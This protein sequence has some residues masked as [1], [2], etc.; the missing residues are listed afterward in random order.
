MGVLITSTFPRDSPRKGKRMARC[1]MFQH[2]KLHDTGGDF[3]VADSRSHRSALW[4]I[5]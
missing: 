1:P 3:P 2:T 5:V 4:S